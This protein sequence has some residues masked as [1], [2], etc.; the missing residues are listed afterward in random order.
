VNVA[1]GIPD[2]IGRMLATRRV[3]SHERSWRRSPISGLRPVSV[4]GFRSFQAG[5]EL[6][7]ISDNS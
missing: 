2:D 1:I 6:P 3:V 7:D 4:V 5:Q